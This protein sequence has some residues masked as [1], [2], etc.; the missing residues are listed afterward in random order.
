[1]GEQDGVN[2]NDTEVVTPARERVRR[3]VPER[4]APHRDWH[5]LYTLGAAADAA[6]NAIP[7]PN[8]NEDDPNARIVRDGYRTLE[9]N[10]RR[11]R[12]VAEGLH[13]GSDSRALTLGA[14]R[15][16]FIAALARAFFDPA[17]V[18][19]L[20][21]AAESWLRV[22]SLPAR[23]ERA[24]ARPYPAANPPN[25]QLPLH[26]QQRA[27][28]GA[29]GARRAPRSGGPQLLGLSQLRPGEW[30]GDLS[31]G[32]RVRRVQIRELEE[33]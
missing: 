17:L 20:Q 6:A 31:I 3:P 12:L 33:V 7:I 26:P 11:G 16:S 8:R 27:E 24:P 18:R 13:G 1:M 9:E 22:L 4:T 15:Q 32:G 5:H 29:D 25:E 14:S 19:P 10:L 30:V 2:A 23:F 21:D 28:Y